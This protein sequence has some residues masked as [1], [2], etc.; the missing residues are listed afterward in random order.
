MPDRLRAGRKGFTAAG[1]HVELRRAGVTAYGV[2]NTLYYITAVAT[3][4]TSH[5]DPLTFRQLLEPDGGDLAWS[6]AQ[7]FC[8]DL[9]AF[10]NHQAAGAAIRLC[11]H[12]LEYAD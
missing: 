2:F 7:V 6:L 10:T 11:L 9:G 12:S 8:D 5:L 3:S 4:G 1:A